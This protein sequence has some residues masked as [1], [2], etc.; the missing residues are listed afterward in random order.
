MQHNFATIPQAEIQ[1]ST[2]DRS[3]NLKTTFDADNLVPIFL[4]EVLPGDTFNLSMSTFARLATPITPILDN[5]YMDFFFFF[6]PTRLVW[7]NWQKL[8][9]EQRNPGDSTDYIMPTMTATAVT[10]YGTNT[11]QDYMGLPT[12]VPGFVHRADPFRSYNLA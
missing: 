8:N 4:D 5:L 11:L 12:L 9:G 10:G 7:D 1:R 3:S 2:F 6:V